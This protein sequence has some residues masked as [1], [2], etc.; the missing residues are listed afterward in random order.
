MT[1]GERYWLR[2]QLA[3]AAAGGALWYVGAVIES[4]FT[5]GVGVGVLVS[6]LALRLLRTQSGDA[7]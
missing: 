3:M 2:F 1:A 5:S 6:A 4:E 7:E